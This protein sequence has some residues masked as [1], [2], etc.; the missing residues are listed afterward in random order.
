MSDLRLSKE[1][2]DIRMIKKAISAY[3]SLADITEDGSEDYYEIV[4][5]QCKYGREKTIAE[6]ENYVIDLMN[7]KE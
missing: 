4:F 2:F 1:I 6:F 7:V 5:A 3:R